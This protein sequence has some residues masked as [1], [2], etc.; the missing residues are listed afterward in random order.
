[1][2]ATL[3]IP[4]FPST[5]PGEGSLELSPKHNQLLRLLGLGWSLSSAAREV[6]MGYESAREVSSS[7]LFRSFLSDFKKQLNEG[8]LVAEHKLQEASPVAAEFLV[9]LMRGNVDPQA[10][11]RIRKEAAVEILK[12]TGV[13]KQ[14]EVRA[15]ITINISEEKLTLINQTLREIKGD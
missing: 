6:G 12:A 10:Q 2:E 11:P 13:V 8:V 7:P 4:S 5:T 14:Q 15:G 1:M 9:D 3:S